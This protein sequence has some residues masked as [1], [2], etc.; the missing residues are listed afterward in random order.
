MTKVENDHHASKADR[1]VPE[2]KLNA[3][4]RQPAAFLAF[5]MKVCSIQ[6]VPTARSR[7]RSV[8]QKVERLSSASY[9][10]PYS[11]VPTPPHE[12]H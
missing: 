5:D 7:L 12:E 9:S 3:I 4:S 6:V 2:E 8:P 10:M 1:I 11:L